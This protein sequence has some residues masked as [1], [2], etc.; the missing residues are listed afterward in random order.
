M[1]IIVFMYDIIVQPKSPLLRVKVRVREYTIE[2]FS[3][4]T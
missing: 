2:C 1:S 3:L 4:V